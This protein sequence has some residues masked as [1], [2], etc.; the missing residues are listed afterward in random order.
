MRKLLMLLLGVLCLCTQVL[1][2]NRS[3]S[4]RITNE[5]GEGIANASVNVK[6]TTTGTVTNSNGAFTLNVGPAA[7]TLVISSVGFQTK[8]ITIDSKT[9]YD[10]RLMSDPQNMNEVVVVAYGTVK[11]GENTAS[12]T[13]ITADKFKNRPITNI[14]AVLEGAAPGIQTLSA[15]GQPGSSQ[16]VRIRGFGSINASN[17]PLYVV[18]GVV[19]SGGLSNFNMDDV[20]SVS[21]LK[22]AASTALYGSRGANGVIIITTKRGKKN[23]NAISFRMTQGISER[24]LPEYERVD[25]FQYY[26]LMWQA[27][28]NSLAYAATPIPIAD[29]NRI[30]SG[31]LP[32]ITTGTNRGKQLYNGTAYNDISQNLTYNPFNVPSTEIVLPDGTINPNAQLK[33]ADDLDWN[34]ELE[35]KGHRQEYTVNYSGGNDKTDF[36]SSFGY[37]DEKGFII[38]SDQKR[39]LGRLNINSQPLNW[40]RTGINLSGTVTSSNQASDGSS[41]GYVNPFFFTRQMGPIYPMYAHDPATGNYMLNSLGQR[42]YDYGNLSAMGIPNRPAGA[43]AGRHILE[44]TKL[45]QS[46][47]SRNIVSGRAYGEILFTKDLKATTNIS[48]DLT[49]Y[50]GSTYD[51]NLVGDGAPAGRASKNT[52]LT[53]SYTFNQLLNY[54]KRF[55]L[56]NL[57]VLAGHENYDLNIED[58]SS[59]RQNQIVAGNYDLDNFTTTNNVSSQTDR[60]RIESYLSRVNYDFD[61]KYFV[62]GSFRRDGN[63]R[64]HKLFRWENFWSIGGAWR[65]DREAFM[66]N[67]SWVNALKLRASYGRVGNDAGIGYYPYQALYALGFNN[68][69]EPG[70]RQSALRN[71]SITW[72]G[73]KSADVAIEFGIL[74]NRISGTIEYY[75]RKSDDLIFGVQLPLSMGGYTI[76]KN[77]GE[78]VNKGWEIQL[79]GDIIRKAGFNWRMDLN[80]STLKNEITK[81]P[82]NQPEIIS[83][84]KKL[85]VGRSIY[86]Y[87]L[88]DWQGVDPTD[89]AALYRATSFVASNSRVRGKDDTVTVSQNN[90]MYVYA[91]SA[92]PKFWGSIGNTFTY[93][94]FEISALLTY[95]VGG[96][97]YDATYA[98]LMHTGT[99]GTALHVDAL[100]AWQKPGDITNVPRMDNSKGG[101][102]DAQSTRWLIDASYLNIRNVSLAY[103]LPSSLMSKISSAGARVFVSGENLYWFS[104]RKGMN[105]QQSFTGVTSNA[106]VPARVVTFGLNVNF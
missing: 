60:H 13:Q 2:Q 44:E 54:T 35:R 3:I 71:D 34:R 5:L 22:D 77:I 32:R 36:F 61:G 12:T 48:L 39:F 57:S 87:W 105:V 90:A 85:A 24:A 83:G 29:A 8:E 47:Y 94:A 40:F 38:R 52:T 16:T 64:F 10:V 96:K 45:N 6:G 97:V 18:D 7:R 99:Y 20:E 104:K 58:F 19:Y 59:S 49:N 84:T 69:A 93:K 89:G 55:G 42:F 65:L 26:P 14:S 11:K 46:R 73:Q 82:D 86:D 92:I 51:N 70:I 103:S 91:G 88:R 68:N 50:F 31:L 72:E 95:Q 53:K 27:Y 98:A 4:G 43:S 23:R 67:V 21:I 76:N 41:T 25:A 17:D 81:M 80:F 15:N 63:S 75:N 106:Y 1:A 74:K 56:H 37:V 101:V 9:S 102:F 78:M 100:K 62:S 28:R 66:Q 33:W 30:A 79:T